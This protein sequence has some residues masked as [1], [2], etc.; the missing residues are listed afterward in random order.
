M[1]RAYPDSIVCRRSSRQAN[2]PP[3]PCE[4]QLDSPP[5]S[6]AFAFR[7]RRVENCLQ[8]PARRHGGAPL[9][10]HLQRRVKRPGLVSAM[11]S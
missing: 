8:Q 11:T 2:T 10:H 6:G 4:F 1:T 3:L 9:P 7:I 5:G